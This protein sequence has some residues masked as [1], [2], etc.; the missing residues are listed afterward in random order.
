[1]CSWLVLK[2]LPAGWLLFVDW[3]ESNQA[4]YAGNVDITSLVI[5]VASQN[6][7]LLEDGSLLIF[8]DST[9]LLSG[10]A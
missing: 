6:F 3:A 1:M 9:F 8:G 10:A 4:Q 7:F 2:V 5:K